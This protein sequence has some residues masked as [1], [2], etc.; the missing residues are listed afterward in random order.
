[1]GTK[2]RNRPVPMT[3]ASGSLTLNTGL[4]G[5]RSAK[6]SARDPPLAG[7]ARVTSATSSA[8]RCT[9]AN[10]L[11]KTSPHPKAKKRR[12]DATTSPLPTSDSQS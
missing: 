9:A 6:P 8:C 4:P 11:G 2:R 5:T 7:T 1:M 10:P 12:G 3:V